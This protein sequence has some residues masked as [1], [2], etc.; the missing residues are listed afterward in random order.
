[1]IRYITTTYIPKAAR[2]AH[3][4]YR[5]SRAANTLLMTWGALAR[6]KERRK[7]KDTRNRGVAKAY[8]A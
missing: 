2:G 6:P 1:L 5:A 4:K 8:P 7:K 3:L